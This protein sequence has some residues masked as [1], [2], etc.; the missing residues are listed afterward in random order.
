MQPEA[1]AMTPVE[2]NTDTVQQAPSE[3]SHAKNVNEMTEAP[4]SK[5]GKGLEYAMFRL[6]AKG[7]TLATTL[8]DVSSM[9]PDS[10]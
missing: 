4:A 5:T 3:K 2:S 10:G 8:T 6:G 7:A 9:L 1:P